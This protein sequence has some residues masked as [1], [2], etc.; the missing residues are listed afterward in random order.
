MKDK[1]E[2]SEQFDFW[3]TTSKTISVV[4]RWVLLTIGVLLFIK[5]CDDEKLIY[6]FRYRGWAFAVGITMEILFTYV[7]FGIVG[8]YF[9]INIGRFVYHTINR[10]IDVPA[11]QETKREI[12]ELEALRRRAEIKKLKKELGEDNSDDKDDT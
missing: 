3:W 4:M 8:W 2:N 7:F 5:G 12:E 6:Y 1:A 11:K 10:T 9:I